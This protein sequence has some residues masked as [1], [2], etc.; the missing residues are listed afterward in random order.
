MS[1]TFSSS[2]YNAIIATILAT[3]LALGNAWNHNDNSY[4]MGTPQEDTV[5]YRFAKI[6][7]T[8]EN[9]TL[10]N[11]GFLDGGFFYAADATP[12]CRFYCYFNINA[13]DM[14]SSQ[15]DCIESGEADFIVTRKYPLSSY[16]PDSSQYR[17][18]DTASQYFSKDLSFTY[19]L[20]QKIPQ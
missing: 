5:Q 3:A 8:V 17:L 19:Y 4:F 2:P 1:K 9:P 20:Y 11:Y 14:W 13:P 15:K 7:N 10:L 16:S 18:V 6:I 12:A